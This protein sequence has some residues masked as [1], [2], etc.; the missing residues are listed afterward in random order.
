MKDN[1]A[2]VACGAPTLAIIFRSAP[3]ERGSDHGEQAGVLIVT[4]HSAQRALAIA[5]NVQARAHITL[6]RTLGGPRLAD[7]ASAAHWSRPQ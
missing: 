1:G 7:T 5:Q 2:V 4:R 3:S 6:W